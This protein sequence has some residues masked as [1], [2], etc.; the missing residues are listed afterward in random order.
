MP[1]D[2][3]GRDPNRVGVFP[4]SGNA[5]ERNIELQLGPSVFVVLKEQHGLADDRVDRALISAMLKW[6]PFHRIRLAAPIPLNSTAP[7]PLT[8][9]TVDLRAASCRPL[10]ASSTR[11]PGVPIGSL[12]G[13][14]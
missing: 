13:I 7:E 11:S 12:A 14:L 8:M 10:V 6:W 2:E 1:L 9:P 4:R 3:L 5:V